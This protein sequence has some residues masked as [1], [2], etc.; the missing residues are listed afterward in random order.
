MNI[1]TVKESKTE[2]GVKSRRKTKTSSS[3]FHIGM[4]FFLLLIMFLGFWSSYFGAALPGVEMEPSIG[5]VPAVIHIHAAVFVGWFLLYIYQSILIFQKKI[6]THNRIGRYGMFLGA[7]VFITGLLVLFLQ[8]YELITNE[9]RT[10]TKGTIGTIGVWMQM[11][12]FA[13]LLFLGY[14]TRR[15]PD[16]HKRYILFATIVLMPAALVR[17]LDIDFIWN[18]LGIW[19]P[20]FFALLILAIVMV[21]DYLT[22]RRIHKVTLIGSGLLVVDMALLFMGF[23]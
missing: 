21:H 1:G 18:N 12:S 19:S 2:G 7:A 10:L 9:G 14:K 13:V 20:V 15:Q 5:G 6:R 4:G 17:T 8:Q 11:V 22:L 23:A 16:F 3:Y